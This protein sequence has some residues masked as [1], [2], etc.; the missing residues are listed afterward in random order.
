MSMKP[1]RKVIIPLSLDEKIF[2]EWTKKKLRQISESSIGIRHLIQW[3]RHISSRLL[4]QGLPL[5]Y[6]ILNF[7][8]FFK[9][10]LVVSSLFYIMAQS[11]DG[12]ST[13]AEATSGKSWRSFRRWR[14]TWM[15]YIISWSGK[16]DFWVQ[17]LQLKL[18]DSCCLPTWLIAKMFLGLVSFSF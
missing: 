18:Q 9:L 4:Q 14:S 13:A 16:T 2:F 10:C 6:P 7:K 17:L 3:G 5:L 15:H 1:Q 11:L 12:C 8:L